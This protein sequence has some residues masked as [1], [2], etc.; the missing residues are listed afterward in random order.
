MFNEG[1][2]KDN[3]IKAALNKHSGYSERSKDKM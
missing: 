1:D 2:A 3:S